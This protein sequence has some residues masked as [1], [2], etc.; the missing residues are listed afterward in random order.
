M[1]QL[2]DSLVNDRDWQGLTPVVLIVRRSMQFAH[3]AC[4]LLV[5]V[6]PLREFTSVQAFQGPERARSRDDTLEL[7][8]AVTM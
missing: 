7:G 2:Y 3:N 6:A 4:V 5:A 1:R 8:G